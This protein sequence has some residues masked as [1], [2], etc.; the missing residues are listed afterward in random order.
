MKV[1]KAALKSWVKI[2]IGMFILS[3]GIINLHE[4]FRITE[5]GVLGGILLIHHWTNFSIP[6]ISLA[7]D[8]MCYGIAFKSFGLK[9]ILK[10][11]V[12]SVILSI[13]LKFWGAMPHFLPF[14]EDYPLVVAIVAGLAVGIGVGLSVSGGASSGGDDALALVISKKLKIKL[15]SAYLFTDLSV[16][17]LSLSYIEPYRILFSLVTVTISSFTID[18]IVNRISGDNQLLGDIVVTNT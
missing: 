14:L 10:S 18:F 13:F 7:L 4:P 11:L 9:F 8:A 12:T 2:T 16:L 5:G 1:S 6:L 17:L 3:F 15:S